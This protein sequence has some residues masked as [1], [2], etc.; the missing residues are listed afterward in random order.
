MALIFATKQGLIAGQMNS[1]LY[2]GP[3]P[4]MFLMHGSVF[5]IDNRQDSIFMTKLRN[6]LYA[7]LSI[8]IVESLYGDILEACDG[9]DRSNFE[10]PRN[11]RNLILIHEHLMQNETF[12]KFKN[13][14][15]E[16]REAIPTHTR[17][18]G[19][20]PHH[21]PDTDEGYVIPDTDTTNSFT[22]TV[23]LGYEVWEPISKLGTKS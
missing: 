23:K 13:L 18:E 11:Y 12:R 1:S 6:R 19:V 4:D 14:D 16:D 22:N 17:E 5:S 2:S 20:P 8:D 7:Y 10:E 15:T 3:D 21:F 9:L